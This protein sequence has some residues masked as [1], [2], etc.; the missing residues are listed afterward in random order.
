MCWRFFSVSGGITRVKQKILILLT[1][2]SQSP[3][4]HPNFRGQAFAHVCSCTLNF[5]SRSILPDVIW[6]ISL[7]AT[8]FQSIF[9]LSP[10]YR[11]G[12]GECADRCAH[13]S[14]REGTSE[15]LVARSAVMQTVFIIVF[16]YIE[17][18]LRG[19]NNIFIC[20]KENQYHKT[21]GPTCS[22]TQTWWTPTI[23]KARHWDT[24]NKINTA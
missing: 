17:S 24:G 10:P 16:T 19:W 6:R 12:Y 11:K 2:G 18:P 13:R 1:M 22:T 15:A 23:K 3:N 8:R 7:I 9:H 5:L 4:D 21:S 14:S 20:Q